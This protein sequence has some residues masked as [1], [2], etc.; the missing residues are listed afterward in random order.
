MLALTHPGAEPG[1]IVYAST[2][3]GQK[4]FN[5]PCDWYSSGCLLL[6]QHDVSST[7]CTF[8][9]SPSMLASRQQSSTLVRLQLSFPGSLRFVDWY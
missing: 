1:C 4:L 7:L 6:G 8:V 2:Q 5:M 3:G 9:P